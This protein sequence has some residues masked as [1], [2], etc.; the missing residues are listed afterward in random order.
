MNMDGDLRPVK[1]AVLR[2]P[3][4]PLFPYEAHFPFR[5]WRCIYT[6]RPS[7]E[8]HWQAQTHT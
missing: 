2:V 8:D 4:L 3:L 6:D 7:R 1:K 5:S